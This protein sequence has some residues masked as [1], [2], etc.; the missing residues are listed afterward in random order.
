MYDRIKE[1][2][3]LY[4]IYEQELKS[5]GII[6]DEQLSAIEKNITEKLEKPLIMPEVNAM[7]FRF[8]SFLN[9]GK[10]F[11]AIIPMIL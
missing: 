8:Q 11:M 1:Q 9:R 6:S 5:D 4:Q 3:P 7:D 2:P 10:V